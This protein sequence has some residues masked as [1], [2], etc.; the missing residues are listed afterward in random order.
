MRAGRS[1]I[2]PLSPWGEGRGEGVVCR[3]RHEAG[4]ERK[5]M[6][7]GKRM[8]EPR[9]HPLT[10]RSKVRRWCAGAPASP[11]GE[12]RFLVP[13]SSW[14]EG[15]GEGLVCRPRHDASDERKAMANG[16]RMTES[17]VH[18]LT[19]RSK[20]RRWCAGAPASPQGER[21]FLVPL[22]SW[23][24][25]RGEGLV[26]RPRHDASDERK[27]M[28]NGERMTE[29]R[30]H[31]LTRRSKV[32]RWCAGAPASPQGERRFSHT[33]GERRFIRSLAKGRGV[34]NYLETAA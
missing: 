1:T 26:C 8:T 5:A 33:Q 15:R 30:V 34:L 17:R 16:E 7:N 21:R 12:R 2:F 20:V 22:S 10:R 14:G 28:A 29:S 9:V 24:E 11:Q 27:A 23:G 3:S 6:A 18:P 32:R 4:G 25:G 19:R 31:P 13:L